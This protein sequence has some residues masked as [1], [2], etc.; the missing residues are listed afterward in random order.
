MLFAFEKTSRISLSCKLVP[1]RYRECEC[2]LFEKEILKIGPRSS[3]SLKNAEGG[4]HFTLLFLFCFVLFCFQW[5]GFRPHSYSRYWTGTSMQL[6]LM[7]GVFVNDVC[8]FL[9]IFPRTSLHFKLVPVQYREYQHGL[10][11][12][13]KM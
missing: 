1:V 10:F 11:F 9:M 4:P 5:S 7:R 6:R 13:L 12:R 3:R 2:G 8:R